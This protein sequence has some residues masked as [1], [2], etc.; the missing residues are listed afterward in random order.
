M[1]LMITLK[2]EETKLTLV[3]SKSV[4]CVRRVENSRNFVKKNPKNCTLFHT[5]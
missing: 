2:N 3:M 1:K 5:R 4:C